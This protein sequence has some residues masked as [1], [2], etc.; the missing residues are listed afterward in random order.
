M[1]YLFYLTVFIAWFRQ[2][3]H[4]KSYSFVFNFPGNCRYILYIM[5]LF[6]LL[7]FSCL[8]PWIP[9]RLTY[10]TAG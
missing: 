2:M 10:I 8:Y 4:K 6:Q 5:C 9:V 3:V 7:I 1:K